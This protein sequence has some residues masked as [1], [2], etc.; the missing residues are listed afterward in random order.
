M[1]HSEIGKIVGSLCI[2]AA[3]AIAAVAYHDVGVP[4]VVIILSVGVL[5]GALT[6]A[7]ALKAALVLVIPLESTETLPQRVVSP[8]CRRR[9]E[10][11]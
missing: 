5:L 4:T 11:Q 10:L 1:S 7:Y 3:T 9:E 6:F 2:P 8:Q